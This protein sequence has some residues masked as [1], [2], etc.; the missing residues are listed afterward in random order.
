MNYFF[1]S[2][3]S[4]LDFFEFIQQ[5]HKVKTLSNVDYLNDKNAELW[6]DT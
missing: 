3:K 1:V 6:Y 5:K 4:T 2:I